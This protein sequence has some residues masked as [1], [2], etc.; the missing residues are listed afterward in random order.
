MDKNDFPGWIRQVAAYRGV[1]Q[2]QIII[3]NITDIRSIIMIVRRVINVTER[4]K[5]SEIHGLWLEDVIMKQY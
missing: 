3:T 4:L 1:H 5:V 2:Q